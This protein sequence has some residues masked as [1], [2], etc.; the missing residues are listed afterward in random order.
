MLTTLHPLSAN[1]YTNFA[2]D[3]RSLGRY[4]TLTDLVHGFVFWGVITLC[5]G[6]TFIFTVRMCDTVLRDADIAGEVSSSTVIENM[7]Y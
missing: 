3:R 7:S 1:V 6:L 4:S 5:D 2:D